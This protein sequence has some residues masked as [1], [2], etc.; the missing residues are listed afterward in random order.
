MKRISLILICMV[1]TMGAGYNGKLPN[2]SSEFAYKSQTPAQSYLPHTPNSEENP[3]LKPVPKENKTYIE[4]VVKKNKTIEYTKD[5]S[6][7]EKI[8]EKLKIC[9]EQ[10]Q[11]IQRFNAITSNLIDHIALLQTTYRGKQESNYL[12]YKSLIT[13]STKARD[14]A[15]LKTESQV[16]NKYLPYSTAGAP[17]KKDNVAAKEKALLSSINETLYVIKNLD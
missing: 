14:I 7:I 11:D 10:G 5:I 16:Y 6:R 2:I 17:Y 9:I 3:T 13:L 12:S 1:F 8:I 4:V 15:I